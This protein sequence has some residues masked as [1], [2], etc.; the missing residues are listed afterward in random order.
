LA[1]CTLDLPA[2]IQLRTSGVKRLARKQLA[3]IV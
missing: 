3:V 1:C 2:R